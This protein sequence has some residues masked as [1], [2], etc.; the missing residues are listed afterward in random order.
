M[1]R[2]QEAMAHP[3]LASVRRFSGMACPFSGMLRPQEAMPY[4][5]SGTHH[6][7]LGMAR[8][9]IAVGKASRTVNS[10]GWSRVNFTN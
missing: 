4:P 5:L 7:F 9:A 2:L 6:P 3:L 10:F 8:L 1:L